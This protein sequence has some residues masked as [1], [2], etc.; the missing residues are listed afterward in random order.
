MN[1]IR[2]FSKILAKPFY[3]YLIKPTK[4]PLEIQ[5]V[6]LAK[7]LKINQNTTFGKAHKFNQISS[8]KKFQEFLLP[9]SYEYFRPYID[10]MTRGEK[11]I[12]IPGNPLYWGKTAGSTGAP[13]LIPITARS[14]K[15][16]I[17]G[18]L[19]IY[20]SY[21]AENPREH[22]KFLDGTVCFFNANPV[23]EY[24]NGIPVGFGTG[25]F[26]QSSQTQFWSPIYRK[27]TYSTGHL[28]R[29]K[30]IQQRYEQ[31]VREITQRD[32]RVF[33]G[34]T[35]VVL[36]LLEIILKYIQEKNPNI[37]CIKDLFPNYQFSILGGESPKFY[38]PRLFSVIGERIDYREVYGATEEIIGV[39]LQ[40]SPGLTPLLT[41]NFLEFLPLNS[42]E[43]LL[44]H[45]VKKQVEYKLLITNFNGLY[46]YMLGDVV[47]FISTDPPLF[48]FS[49][50]EGTI[51][52]ASEKMTVQ[53]ISEAL[54]LTNEEHNC[55][56]MEYCV[57]GK[58]TPKPHYIF[59]LEFLPHQTP[60]KE[61]EYLQSLNQNLMICNPVYREQLI[62]IRAMNEPILWIVR[63]G[64]F[65]E[66]EQQNLERGLPMGQHK[67]QHLSINEKILQKFEDYIQKVVRL[68]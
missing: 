50:R 10:K 28:F 14:I 60:Q 36:G 58:Y 11:D 17:R 37:K 33:S 35:T 65:S 4:E 34:V 57:I 5:K 2:F 16:A 20:L 49:H 46:T 27:M 21:I 56:I 38:E 9:H 53:Q 22:S 25:V 29:I 66:L 51:N 15:N 24:M 43:R 13:K 54:T 45:E 26:N 55:S 3:R 32:I 8:I 47:K 44:I 18:T 61:R 19:L 48:I 40:D 1:F 67:I 31:L 52:M 42:T 12:L 64:T 41:A 63:K 59:I 39:Q 7:I 68:N 23:I 62:G 6:L 30:N